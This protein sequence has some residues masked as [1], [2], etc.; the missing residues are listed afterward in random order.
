MPDGHTSLPNKPNQE[1]PPSL[2]EEPHHSPV[3]L[4]EAH[5]GQLE[6]ILRCKNMST[7]PYAT[8]KER[9]FE[10][11]RPHKKESMCFQISI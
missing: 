3:E 11:K 2:D 4:A 1:N 6:A 9:T 5:Y 10:Y 7:R 8:H